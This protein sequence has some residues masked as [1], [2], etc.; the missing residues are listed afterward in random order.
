M[1]P[2]PEQR[3]ATFKRVEE[4]VLGRQ[5]CFYCH[6]KLIIPTD[7]DDYWCQCPKCGTKWQVR[8]G[9]ISSR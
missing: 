8:D 1:N 9:S 6:T 2:T 7:P 4:S 5:E 3:A